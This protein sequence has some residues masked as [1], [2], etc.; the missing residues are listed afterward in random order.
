MIK[1]IISIIG[2]S[3]I[4]VGCSS[5]NSDVVKVDQA[6]YVTQM[7][8]KYKEF[9]SLAYPD[10][11]NEKTEDVINSF[12]VINSTLVSMIDLEG[13]SDKSSYEAAIDKQLN[14]LLESYKLIKEGYTTKDP[15][16]TG[17]SYK[18]VYEENDI[19]VGYFNEYDPLILTPAGSE[20]SVDQNKK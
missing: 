16:L 13:P 15:A 2:C 19:L 6:D 4:L 11:T 14:A 18:Q 5:S 8:A 17:E 12:D 10:L 7:S 3:L 1:K 20:N 9:L